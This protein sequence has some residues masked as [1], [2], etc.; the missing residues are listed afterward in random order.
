MSGLKETDVL[1]D[2][3]MMAL[4][5][6]DQQAAPAAIA[7]P[8]PQVRRDAAHQHGDGHQLAD[9]RRGESQV[10]EVQRQERRGGAE[11]G[12]IEQIETGQAPVGQRR[13]GS[14]HRAPV[15]HQ[16]STGVDTFTSAFCPR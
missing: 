1:E 4:L 13:H 10:V 8:P 9:A 7:Q 16:R 15:A 14:V 3:Q 6:H 2:K 5:T 11:Q 12:E